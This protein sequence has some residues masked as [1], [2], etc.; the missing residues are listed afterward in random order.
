MKGQDHGQILVCV[1]ILRFALP[2]LHGLL[3]IGFISVSFNLNI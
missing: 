3:L 2:L 1:E